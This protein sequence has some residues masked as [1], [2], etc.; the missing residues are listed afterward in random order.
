LISAGV[1]RKADQNRNR[2]RQQRREGIPDATHHRR[3]QNEDEG[4]RHRD[5]HDAGIGAG[6]VENIGRRRER[7][8]QLPA[9]QAAKDGDD[10]R[11]D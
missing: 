9:E 3:Q 1:A 4:Q 11:A 2:E 8:Q 10:G 6:L 7:D 5:H